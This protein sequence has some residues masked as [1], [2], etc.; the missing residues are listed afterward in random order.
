ML[1]Q[2]RV[3]VRL[4]RGQRN[5]RSQGIPGIAL[6]KNISPGGTQGQPDAQEQDT[7]KTGQE[8]RNQRA[9]ETRHPHNFGLPSQ[10]AR[11]IES[12]PGECDSAGYAVLSAPYF[13]KLT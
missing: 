11:I 7:C 3:A 6:I 2:K 12:A 10:V 1:G 9:D 4:F 13:V 5:A 8:S